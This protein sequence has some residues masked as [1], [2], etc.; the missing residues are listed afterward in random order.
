MAKKFVSGSKAISKLFNVRFIVGLAVL[1]VGVWLFFKLVGKKTHITTYMEKFLDKEQFFNGIQNCEGSTKPYSLMFFYM[2][3]CPHCIDFKPVWADFLDK[4]KTGKFSDKLCVADVSAENDSL[5]EKY[6]VKAFPTVLL[7]N[8][9]GGGVTTFEGQRT[10][11]GLLNF[12]SQ[13]VS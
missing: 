12:V 3:T 1:M 10:P 6:G 7:V 11:E 9:S 8:N 4:V 13:N 5:L 2:D